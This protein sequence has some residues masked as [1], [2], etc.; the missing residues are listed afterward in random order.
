MN[1][2]SSLLLGLSSGLACISTCLPV[3]LPILMG[4]R[5]SVGDSA[6]YVAS[7]LSGRLLA[8]LAAA[9]ITAIFAGST[10]LFSNHYF[11][12][13]TQLVSAI[14][15]LVFAFWKVSGKCY[16]PLKN[17]R[18]KSLFKHHTLLLTAALGVSTSAVLCPPFITL[19]MQSL[20]LDSYFSVITSF[21]MFFVG[22]LPYFLPV[23]FVGLTRK[24]E[25]IKVIGKYAAIIVGLTYLY[26][27]IVLIINS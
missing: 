7:F 14:L 10:A 27:T 16:N 18:F 26:R 23:P 2:L 12:A 22:T 19:I 8:Y 24:N 6:V 1:N 17:K 21:I 4:R 3:L 25:V 11:L 20:Q 13:V 9:L 15:M 5:S